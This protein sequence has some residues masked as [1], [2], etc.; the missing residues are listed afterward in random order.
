MK[1]ITLLFLA[2]L[3]VIGCS[4]NSSQH[5]SS[6]FKEVS[7]T[8]NNGTPI[9]AHFFKNQKIAI[10]IRDGEPTELQQEPSGSGFHYSNGT[11]SI[12][13]KGNDLM[14]FNGR[15]APIKCTAL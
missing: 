12:R 5:I 4:S 14:I 9:K 6:G 1:T 3:T 2:A 10:L 15:M 13:G 7:F 8:C 11:T